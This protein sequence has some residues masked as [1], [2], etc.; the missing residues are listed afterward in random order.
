MRTVNLYKYIDGSET[1]IT[2][3]KRTETDEPYCYRL[4]A[5]EG[6]AL[7]NGMDETP[8]VD[9]HAPS[10]WAELPEGELTPEQIISRLEEIL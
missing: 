5:D 10:E 7:T 2:P 8:C 3:N 9:T 6:K 4:I 1:I